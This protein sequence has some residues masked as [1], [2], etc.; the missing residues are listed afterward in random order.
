MLL[1]L[2]LSNLL[3]YRANF[4][5][6]LISSMV[7]GIFS[8]L[9]IILL[10]SRSPTVYGWTREEMIM[11]MAL[12]NIAI[13]GVYHMIF[14]RSLDDIPDIIDRGKL[15]TL[16]LKPIDS[17]FLLSTSTFGYTQFSRIIMGILVLVYLA[18]TTG[19]RITALSVIVFLIL[20][21]FGIILLYSIWF[22][23]LTLL[24][25]NTRLSNLVDLLYHFNDLVRFPP[26]MYKVLKNYAFFILPYTFILV[27]PAKSIFQRLSL[28]EAFTLI[29]LSMLFFLFSRLF[30]RFALRSYT[31]AS[32]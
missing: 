32:A 25:W 4:F 15:D 19:L 31:G 12:Y 17:Q 14:S 29:V 24:I 30:W 27:T 13:G 20:S 1:K 18:N 21:I 8:F 11:L 16:L 23:V 2:N 7:F 6:S 28:L 22:S 26:E 5:N 3:T 9:L 10:T